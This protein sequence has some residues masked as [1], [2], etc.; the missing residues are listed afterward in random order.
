MP[1]LPE[2]ETIRRDLSK[3]YLQ[4]SVIGT[5]IADPRLMS[6][7]SLHAW[8]K[9]VHGQTWMELQRQ[10]KYLQV[11]LASGERIVFHLRMTGQL[12]I[13][14]R[15]PAMKWRMRLRFQNAKDLY[16]CDQRRFGEVWLLSKDQPWHNQHLP[17]PDAL[18]ELTRK[19]FGEILAK[20]TTRIHP[21]LLD[22][23]RISG[24]GNIYSQEALFR[25]AIRPT[26]QAGKI[27]KAETTSLF[28]ALRETLK[29]AL[30]HRG[31]TSRNYRDAYGRVGSAQLLHAVYRKGGKPCS[32]C[33]K[34]LKSI[35]VGGR[36]TVYCSSCQR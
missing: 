11:V 8:K 6:L 34:P 32:R 23:R 3:H 17:G 36:G 15:P 20:R 5:Q 7:S 24:I 25:A 30:E 9:R 22:Q 1:E 4:Q 28:T 18:N 13:L 31:S 27:T 29:A 10:G 26:R 19:K 33:Q 16:F 14:D 35:R 2:V 12:V 21:L